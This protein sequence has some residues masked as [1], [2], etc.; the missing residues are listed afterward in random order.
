MC[1]VRHDAETVAVLQSSLQPSS[2]CTP[3]IRKSF[4]ELGQ[5]RAFLRFDLKAVNVQDEKRQEAIGNE[6]GQP[7]GPSQQAKEQGQVHRISAVPVNARRDDRRRRLR[8]KRIDRRLRPP[9]LKQSSGSDR[10]AHTPGGDGDGLAPWHR[11]S[12][13]RFGRREE[14]HQ[15]GEEQRNRRRGN[16][17][18]ERMHVIP[19]LNGRPYVW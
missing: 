18:V 13:R 6:M 17:V 14:P 3:I 2:N 9:K 16:F 12:H 19:S 8:Q 5:Q 1:F 15:P 7:D 11:Q 10:D 4:T